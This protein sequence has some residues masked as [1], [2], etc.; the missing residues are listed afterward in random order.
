MKL[1]LSQKTPGDRDVVTFEECPLPDGMGQEWTEGL[2]GIEVGFM[3]AIEH[4]RL[5]KV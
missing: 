2:S 5:D 3:E 1:V 4:E